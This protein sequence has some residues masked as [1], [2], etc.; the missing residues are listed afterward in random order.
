ML[1]VASFMIVEA[2]EV[3]PLLCSLFSYLEQYQP[4]GSTEFLGEIVSCSLRSS[5]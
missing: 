1:E 4:V 3:I 2:L 5:S